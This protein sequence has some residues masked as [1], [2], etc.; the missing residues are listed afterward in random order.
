M[1][2]TALGKGRLKDKTFNVILGYK[3]SSGPACDTRDPVKKKEW[4]NVYAV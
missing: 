4:K 2:V 1:P 3:A